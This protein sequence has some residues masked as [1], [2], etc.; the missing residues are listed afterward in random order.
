ME[1]REFRVTFYYGHAEPGTAVDKPVVSFL[2]QLR[3]TQPVLEKLV[4]AGLNKIR[5]AAYHREPLTKLVD[6][7]SDIYELRVG[8][9]DIARVFFFFH[10][11]QEI[12]VTNGYVKKA[13]K[14]DR[15]QI[16]RAIRCKRDWEQRFPLGND[17]RRR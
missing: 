2:S 14:S 12:V 4:V 1:P 6:S 5:S 15:E 7:A 10:A 16:D 9:R 11:R 17:P 13:Q 3:E 8:N